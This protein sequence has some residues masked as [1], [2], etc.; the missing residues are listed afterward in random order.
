MGSEEGLKKT[1]YRRLK[2]LWIPTDIESPCSPG[3]PDIYYTNK[4]FERMGWVE[5]KHSHFWPMRE[6]TILK[7]KHYTK[8]QKNW[9]RTH[10]NHGCRVFLMIQVERDYLIFDGE[11]AQN[12][13]KMTK[14]EM[15]LFSIMTWKNY[16]NENELIKIL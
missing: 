13:G 1:L 6:T 5:L 3:V 9:I 12:V 15:F 14:K 7:L 10:H 4:I 2:D 16:I 11:N 8:Q